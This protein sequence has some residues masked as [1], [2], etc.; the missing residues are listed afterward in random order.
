M[1]LI[2]QP[3]FFGNICLLAR[4]SVTPP[5]KKIHWNTR[6]MSESERL[7]NMPNTSI[8]LVKPNKGF[9]LCIVAWFLLKDRYLR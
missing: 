6:K 8:G 4:Y 2:F 7:T 9:K 1:W 3:H 5:L